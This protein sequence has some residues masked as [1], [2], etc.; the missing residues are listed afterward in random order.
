MAMAT[1]IQRRRKHGLSLYGLQTMPDTIAFV[2]NLNPS[3]NRQSQQ[4]TP[5]I[6]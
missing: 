6:D 1:M 2:A 5:S 3:P 4:I